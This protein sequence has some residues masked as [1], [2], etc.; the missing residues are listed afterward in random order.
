[1]KYTST[2]IEQYLQAIFSVDF[3]I[4]EITKALKNYNLF[5]NT[6]III[7]SDHGESLLEHEIFFNHHGLYDVSVHVPLIFHYPLR[8]SVPKRI[9]AIVQ[10][11]D[12]LP[13]ILDIL[14]IGYELEFD[15]KSLIPLIEGKTKKN[16]D[17]IL[18]EE[19]YAQR[20]RALRTSHYK[21]IV[22]LYKEK[23]ICSLCGYSHS[24]DNQLYN[25]KDDPFESKNIWS[26]D[27]K[28]ALELKVKMEE[29]VRLLL[30][31]REK[32][33]IKRRFNKK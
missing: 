26:F 28:R 23:N 16:H 14:N 13:T 29:R 17:F 21:T 3:H 25:L 20:K 33:I 10:H 12:I 11:I 22:N 19:S 9:P 7:T 32:L 18:L 31:K 30:R 8:L 6:L 5:D 27:T 4:G 1:M 2:V 15:G 24:E